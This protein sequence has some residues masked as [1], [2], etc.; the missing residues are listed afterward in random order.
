MVEDIPKEVLVVEDDAMIRIVA[1]DALGDRG[2]MAWEAADASEALQVLE[3]RPRIGLL[4]T[5]VNMP[6]KMNGLGLAH[7]VS[8][9]RP[10]VELIVTSGAVTLA[11]SDLPDHGTF[12]PKPYPPERLAEIVA[13]KLDGERR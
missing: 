11:D 3:Q 2:I 5:D 13:E 6:G 9:T 7:E 10:E 4:F 12:L 1:A 8:V